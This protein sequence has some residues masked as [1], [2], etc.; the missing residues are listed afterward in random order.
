MGAGSKFN[1]NSQKGNPQ[2]S[3]NYAGGHTGSG[4]YQH[5]GIYSHG[6]RFKRRSHLEFKPD[7]KVEYIGCHKDFSGTGS[8]MNRVRKC[9]RSTI[10]VKMN[11]TDKI[12]YI[13]KN[14][15]IIC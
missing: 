2:P 8:V 1:N 5:G 10:L 12:V 9:P 7:T 15:L 14:N 11:N 13:H 4:K 3:P 6:F